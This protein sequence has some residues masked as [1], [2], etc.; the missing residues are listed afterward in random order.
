MRKHAFILLATLFLGA[1]NTY[2]LKYR[3]DPQPSGVNI[4]ADFVQLQ[5]SVAVV[6]DTNSRRLEEIFVK[7]SDGTVVRPLNISYP[8]SYQSSSLGFGIGGFSGGGHGGVGTGVGVGIPV[9][10]SESYG[11]TTATFAAEPL[12]HA[13]WELHIKVEGAPEA[14]L[15][16]FGGTPNAK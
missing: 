9:G 15:P 2:N 4:F 5:D 10:P 12:G 1:C 14:V 6:I 13:P 11:T 7:K 3:P 16:Q 8:A